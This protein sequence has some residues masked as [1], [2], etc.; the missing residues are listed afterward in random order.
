[1]VRSLLKSFSKTLIVLRWQRITGSFVNIFFILK[2]KLSF[3]KGIYNSFEKLRNQQL[4][5]LASRAKNKR[6]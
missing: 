5:G 2:D 6:E 4:A 1:M 3:I